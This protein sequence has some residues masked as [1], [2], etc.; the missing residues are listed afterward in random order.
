MGREFGLWSPARSPFPPD[1]ETLKSPPARGARNDSHRSSLMLLRMPFN[2]AFCSRNSSSSAL[3][4][5]PTAVGS[6]VNGGTVAIG[7]V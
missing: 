6:A 5:P 3:A 1:V 4:V 2:N 7:S